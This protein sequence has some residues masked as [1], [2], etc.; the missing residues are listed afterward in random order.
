MIPT[1]GLTYKVDRLRELEL[2]AIQG[3]PDKFVPGGSEMYKIDLFDALIE[4]FNDD[5]HF[6]QYCSTPVIRQ[7]KD[8]KPTNLSFGIVAFDFDYKDDQG[9]KASPTPEAYTSFLRRLLVCDFTPNVVYST[10][11]GAR[12][13]SILADAIT[14]PDE[15]EGRYQTLLDRYVE[16]FPERQWDF[17]CD[18]ATKDWTRL[19]RF[20]LVMR[21]GVPTYDAHVGVFHTDPFDLSKCKVKAKK[22]FEPVL[23]EPIPATQKARVLAQAR[24]F[25]ENSQPAISGAGG[26]NKTFATACAMFKLGLSVDEVRPLMEVFNAKCDPPWSDRELEHK[27]NDAAKATGAIEVSK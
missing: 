7:R 2:P 8:Y 15:F 11:N 27:L 18:P 1:V 10:K 23:V 6:T 25:I 9:Q 26:H 3:T 4:R 14:D 17:G 16:L 19:F 21:D 13:I 5:D 20:P 12:I 24:R 22:K